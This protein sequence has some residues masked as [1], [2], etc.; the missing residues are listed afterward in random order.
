[1][2][3]EPIGG[4]GSLVGGAVSVYGS[5]MIECGWDKWEAAT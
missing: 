1:M 2:V 3:R 5:L 4:E